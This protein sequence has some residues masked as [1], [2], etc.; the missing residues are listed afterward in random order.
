MFLAFLPR[1]HERVK[2]VESRWDWSFVTNNIR[3]RKRWT[4]SGLTNIQPTILAACGPAQRRRHS[5]EV[6]SGHLE[7]QI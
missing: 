7:R 4:S 3:D 6:Y 2:R 5:R 1:S